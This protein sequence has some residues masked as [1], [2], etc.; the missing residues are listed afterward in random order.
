[1][2]SSTACRQSSQLNHIPAAVILIA[3]KLVPTNDLGSLVFVKGQL[4]A[5]VLVPSNNMTDVVQFFHQIRKFPSEFQFIGN[6][7]RTPK[8]YLEVTPVC[9]NSVMRYGQL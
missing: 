4:M 1:M 7:F 6:A 5:A 3:L 9:T 2:L 8:Q